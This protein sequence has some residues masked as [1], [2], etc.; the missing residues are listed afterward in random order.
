MRR[1]RNAHPS[2]PLPFIVSLVY[3]S[4]LHPG[5]CMFFCA[6][7]VH[8]E[9]TA[10]FEVL[11][12][13]GLLRMWLRNLCQER[14]GLATSRR[15]HAA[16]A[17]SWQEATAL[18]RG[19]PLLITTPTSPAPLSPICS[20]TIHAPSRL[21]NMLFHTEVIVRERR[22]TSGTRCSWIAFCPP[23]C[24]EP[25]GVIGY[26]SAASFALSQIASRNRW[27]EDRHMSAS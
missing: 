19:A 26:R 25:A 4:A 9:R 16:A 3:H 6:R 8:S 22:G 7:S 17:F 1:A 13:P 14:T 5:L 2:S 11:C 10:A 21:V 24:S 23:L 20:S 18:V 27:C 12:W 15:G